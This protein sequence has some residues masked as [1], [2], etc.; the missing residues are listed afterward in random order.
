MLDKVLNIEANKPYADRKSAA[1]TYEKFIRKHQ[2]QN[3]FPK[4]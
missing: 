4:D 1:R 2:A 3:F